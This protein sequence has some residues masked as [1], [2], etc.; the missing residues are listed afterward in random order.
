ML[1][2]GTSEETLELPASGDAEFRLS[3][4]IISR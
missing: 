2:F 3:T 4:I 1:M